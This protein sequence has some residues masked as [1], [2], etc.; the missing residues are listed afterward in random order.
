MYQWTYGDT[1][2]SHLLQEQRQHDAEQQ[3]G[4]AVCVDCG[5]RVPLDAE[6]LG[7]EQGTHAPCIHSWFSYRRNG[8][9][10]LE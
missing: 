2:A 7:Y 3:E 1:R 4:M 6:F 5:T 8:Q 10:V 9:Y